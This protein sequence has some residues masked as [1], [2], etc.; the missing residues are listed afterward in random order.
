M[1]NYPNKLKQKLLSL[2]A[3][4]AMNKELYVKD[5][6]RDFARKRKLDLKT[7]L[8][9]LLSMGGNSLN[10]ELLDYFQYDKTTATAS[11]FVQ[12]RDKL[13]HLLYPM[14]T[15]LTLMSI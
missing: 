15:S 7:M 6:T 4:I 9:I 2:I 10:K 14:M 11:A 12:C 1:N 3:E 8:I 13:L 5:P